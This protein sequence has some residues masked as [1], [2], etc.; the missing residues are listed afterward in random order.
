P[1]V[2]SSSKSEAFWPTS[3]AAAKRVIANRTKT[4]TRLSRVVSAGF[5]PSPFL[6]LRR[7]VAETIQLIKIAVF[8]SYF[9][10]QVNPP[11]CGFFKVTHLRLVNRFLPSLPKQRPQCDF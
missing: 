4:N 5:I 3:R 9:E 2:L 11:I 6:S 1:L 7:K 8:I 10:P